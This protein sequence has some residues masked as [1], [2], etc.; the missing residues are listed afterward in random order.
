MS[1]PTVV[2][3][4]GDG[5]GPEVAR[6]AKLVLELVA[7]DVAV[8]ERLI[9]AAAIRA[10]GDPLPEETLAAC[11]EA[12]AVL[13]GPVGDP[14]FDAADVRPEQG[15]LRLRAALDAYANL[16]PAG[17]VL[18][19]REL[20][21]GLYFGAS[22]V[23]DDGTVFDTCEYHPDQVRRVVRRAFALSRGHVTSVDKANVL[24]TSRM[25]RRVV[26]E[27][28][29]QFPDVR[30][31]H[32]L[33]D[34]AA[35]QLATNTEQFDTI[36]TE[37]MFGD[38]LSD[39]AAAVTGGIGLAPSASLADGGPGIFE[40]VHGSAPDIAGRGIAN[41]TAMLRSTAL[42]LDHGLGRP[43]DAQAL[44]RA[45]D[46]ALESAPTFDLGGTASTAEFGAAV[47]EQLALTRA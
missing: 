33:V 19:V 42:L 24:E 25:W 40:P 14:E 4:P 39:L 5:V 23:R 21:G 29:S 41:P 18:I 17:D 16:R 22:G 1:D 35:M 28:A 36:V 47:R 32:M 2:L 15:L 44:M 46:A 45:V 11:R 7:P 27:V 31:E 43:E 8:E 6:E 37:N 34:N 30:V 26:N 10:T 9:G 3:L 12:T 38:I 13:K 20:V